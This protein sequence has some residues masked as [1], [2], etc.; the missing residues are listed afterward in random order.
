MDIG[1]P[2]VPRTPRKDIMNI[3]EFKKALKDNAIPFKDTGT[4]RNHAIYVDRSLILFMGMAYVTPDP[5]K[6]PDGAYFHVSCEDEKALRDLKLA[7]LS[8]MFH[9]YKKSHHKD[10]TII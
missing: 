1:A 9:L 4:G 5:I 7:D 3:T 2:I 10:K 8:P 6:M